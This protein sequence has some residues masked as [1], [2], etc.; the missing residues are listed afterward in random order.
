MKAAARDISL[1]SKVVRGIPSV[2]MKFNSVQNPAPGSTALTTLSPTRI[3]RIVQCLKTISVIDENTSEFVDACF[4][5]GSAVEFL[6][7]CESDLDIFYYE[8]K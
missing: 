4:P 2:E 6:V 3:F 8:V 7:N 1:V 5:C